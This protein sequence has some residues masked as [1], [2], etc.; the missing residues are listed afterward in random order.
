VLR[1]LHAVSLNRKAR[2]ACERIPQVEAFTFHRR[3]VVAV[4]AL[5]ALSLAL[6]ASS[7]MAAASAD[8]TSLDAGYRQMYNLD[9][10]T[11]HQTFTAWERAYPE[12]PMGPVSNAAAYLFA[13]FDRM[14]ILES[15][16][17][18]DDATFEKRKKFV[19]DLK[20]RA[21]FEAEL[22]QGDRVAD[23]VLA[24]LPDNHAALFA[25]VMVGGLRSD[26]LA[27]VEKRN[28]AALST[29]KRSRAIAENLLAMDPSY[30][31]A[32]L[33]IGV[34]NY[35]LSVNSAPVRWLLRIGG[36]RTDKEEGLAKLR[37]TAVKGRYLAP[38]ARVLLAVAAL[39]DHDRNGARTLLSSLAQDFPNNPLYRRELARIER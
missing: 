26:Y 21:A 10:D 38:Y 35:L 19:P 27:L 33:A 30:Y 3:I 8:S 13:E 23:R 6:F 11:A 32:Y 29:I 37:L 28:L 24:R 22:A 5:L 1:F 16:L 7:S 39:R 34:E 15:E 2:S 12:D 31:D 17:F 14:H 18:V 36:A 25:K 20:A 4:Q 9:F